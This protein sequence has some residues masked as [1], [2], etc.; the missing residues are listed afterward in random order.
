LIRIA[1]FL[2][3]CLEKVEPREAPELACE[4]N[5]VPPLTGWCDNEALLGGQLD[6]DAW[7]R[8]S[9]VFD[10]WALV[11]HALMHLNPRHAT[12][13]D[14]LRRAMRALQEDALEAREGLGDRTTRLVAAAGGAPVSVSEQVA[15]R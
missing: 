13:P 3:S 1:G 15:P 4:S 7:R 11:F 8:I 14:D 10:Q 9:I 5:V 2:G 6:Y 12:W